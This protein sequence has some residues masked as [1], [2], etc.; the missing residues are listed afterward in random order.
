MKRLFNLIR[1]IFRDAP[2]VGYR[3]YLTYRL[4]SYLGS[5][6]PMRVAVEGQS[7]LVRPGTPDLRVAFQ[8]LRREFDILSTLLPA[9]FDG[10]IVDAGGYIGA[11]AIKLSKMYPKATVVS[12]EPS[13]A[14]YAMLEKNIQGHKN[15][16]A[17]KSALHSQG[18]QDVL[19]RD[20]GTGEW[21]F[22]IALQDTTSRSNVLGSVSTISLSD[23][24][25]KFGGKPIGLVKLDIEGGEYEILKNADADLQQV[26]LLFVELHDRIVP[27]CSQVFNAFSQ[28]RWVINAGGEKHLSMIGKPVSILSNP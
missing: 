8:S 4:R 6:D 26:P 9:N 21:G 12:I 22:S 18:G 24:S 17:L 1:T 25:R 23:I 19:L 16:H 15:I 11:A 10:I 7:V 14:N 20:R 5:K 28:G 27:G 13:D 2:I 3:A